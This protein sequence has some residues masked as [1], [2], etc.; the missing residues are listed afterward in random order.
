MLPVA[1]RLVYF[2]CFIALAVITVHF[3]QVYCTC[4]TTAQ[5]ILTISVS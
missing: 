2:S 1:L 3:V 5:N 4:P